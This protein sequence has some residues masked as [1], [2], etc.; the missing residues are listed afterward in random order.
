M[1]FLTI[2][3]MM[4][5]SIYII[6]KNGPQSL[7]PSYDNGEKFDLANLSGFS[8]L[9]SNVLLGFLMHHSIPVILCEVKNE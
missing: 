3:T 6:I 9:F 7:T 8:N 5:G 2:M 1:R 4:I